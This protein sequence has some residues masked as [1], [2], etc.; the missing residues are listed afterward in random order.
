MFAYTFTIIVGLQKLWLVKIN[1][2]KYKRKI[3][4][5]FKPTLLSASIGL[6][7]A[8]TAVDAAQVKLTSNMLNQNNTASVAAVSSFD[9]G[10]QQALANKPS[11]SGMRS[12]FDK[13]LGKATFLWA[14]KDTPAPNLTGIAKEQHVAFTAEHYM[15]AL[16]GVSNVKGAFETAEMVN[17]HDINQ[18]A[19]VA[20]YRQNINGIEVFNRELNVMLDRELNLVASSGYFSKNKA[21]SH[22]LSLFAN[23][24][25]AEQAITAAIKALTNNSI[26]VALTEVE[27]AG[28]YQVFDIENLNGDK[29]IVGQPRAKKVIFDANDGLKSAY[30]IEVNVANKD[31]V[32]SE[33]F[34]YVIDSKTNKVLFKNTLSE[35]DSEFTYRVF[36]N[37]NGYPMEGPHGDV[38]PKLTEGLDTTTIVDMP[39]VTISQLSKISTQD[40]WLTEDAVTTS[41]NNVFA[42]ADVVAPQGFTDGDFTAEVTAPQTFDYEFREDQRDNSFANRKSAIVNLFY[43]NNFLHDFFY[44][45]G[46]DEA[47][48]NAQLS[49]Y[50]RGGV[51]GDPLEVQA[52]DYAGLNNANMSTPADGGSP[53]M[54]QFLW[55]SKDAALGV[56]FG[57]TVTSDASI[58]LLQSTQLA[59]FGAQQYSDITGSV[60]RLIDDTDPINDGCESTING[61]D[62]AGK[63]AI[64]DRGACNFTGKVLN[65]QN[66]G[67]V[68]AI[69]V[70]NND[71]GTPAPMGGAD[72]AV[73][74]PSIGL[75]FAEGK[76]IYDLIDNGTAVTVEMF[77]NFPLKDSSFDN[78]IVAH[79]WGHYISNRLIGN[80]NGLFNFQGRNMGEG[81]GDFHSLM[82]LV[83]ESDLAIPDN[84]ELGLSYPTGTY[85][86][87]FDTGIRRA[88]YSTDMTVN[89]LTFQYIES[90][91]TPPG[92]SPT[93][94]GSPH[95]A[96]ELWAASLWEVYVSLINTHGFTTAQ[97]KMANY[98]IAGYK[99]TPIAP[100]FTEARDAILANILATDSD[101]FTLALE[102]FA[103]RGLGLGAVSPDR[104]SQDNVGV[105]ESFKTELTSYNANSFT[106]NP[107]FSG[108]T[109]GYCSDDGVLD[110][111]ETGTVSVT[112]SNVGSEQLSGVT[113]KIEVVSDHDVTLENDGIVTFADVSPFE[114]STSV[115]IKITLNTAGTADTLE[116]KVSFPEAVE[117]DDIQE[118][119]DLSLTAL[120][121]LDFEKLPP[122]S[123][124]STDDMET[125]ALLDNWKENIMRGGELAA[126]TRSID[127]SGNVGFF[128]SLNPSVDLGSQVMFLNNNSFESDLAYETDTFEI[129]YGGD[130]EM[131][132]WHFYWLEETW[133][134]GVIEI[135]LNGGN[136]VDVTDVGGTFDFGYTSTLQPG[137]PSQALG[138]DR[139][140]FTG[141]NGDLATFAGNMEKVNF[142]TAL[143]GNTARLRFRIGTDGAVADFGWFIDQVTISNIASPVFSK[144][145]AGNLAIC[146]NVL[147]IVNV[148]GTSSISESTT[149]SL[150]AV[151][152]DRNG[153]ALSYSWAQTS[154]PAAT[155]TDADQ[156]VLSFTPP[157]I[158]SNTSLTFTVTVNDGTDSVSVSQTVN[159]TN[160]ALP[161]VPV[162]RPSSG[163]GAM[164]WLGLLL[165][166]LAFFRRR[167]K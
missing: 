24:G 101:D 137:N 90:D 93:N 21:N 102:A 150:T 114:N 65:A 82:F 123:Q 16:T 11:Q 67:A 58:G 28:K 122:V 61:P 136:W 30:Y 70:N 106:L 160:E 156:S 88:P 64:I 66:A 129:G 147:P 120:V 39:L 22:D 107:S 49:N 165:V 37:Q 162:V 52:Q 71:D 38:I 125:I 131:S 9:F 103:K 6:V 4:N 62:L 155:L 27:D 75:N 121:N 55:N 74:I 111:G 23:L 59:A 158:N 86:E 51:E 68:A 41:G 141:I 164:G 73:T 81:W 15:T 5:Y 45:Y 146:D 78:G 126:D 149:S 128:S 1:K 18:G 10:K 97:D 44:D 110:Q 43:M 40:P 32:D 95:A 94:G 72:A 134:G 133:D 115:P 154:G 20:K 109:L 151:A 117:G 12:H 79:E 108:N 166:P 47:A 34:S 135:S 130:F 145:V 104:F 13:N 25:T 157:S 36:A 57:G 138:S 87:N 14:N 96:G 77:S 153:D 159:V 99:M 33:L 144:A 2:K 139:G 118:A 50:G 119:T 19:I 112:I 76:A 80:A 53:R 26:D 8:A 161:T 167:Q 31:S 142:G 105:I 140:T 143:N 84:Q 63:I 91:S 100:T 92:L 3:M 46:F 152:T 56:D 29:I 54:Q 89:P 48:G 113:A 60:V 85:V 116:L 127:N 42:Y 163:G 35:N 83:L 98:L 7:F 17:L 69:I 132:F 124:K 148:T